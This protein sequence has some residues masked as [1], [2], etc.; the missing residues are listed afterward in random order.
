MLIGVKG[1][2]RCSA[3][4]LRPL[5]PIARQ[6]VKSFAVL[7]TRRTRIGILLC[8][9]RSG[10]SSFPVGPKP[11]EGFSISI[12][13]R[14]H[15]R[16]PADRRRT[17]AFLQRNAP[18]ANAGRIS[19]LCADRIRPEGR[20]AHAQAWFSL[21]FDGRADC[22]S[23]AVSRSHTERNPAVSLAKPLRPQHKPSVLDATALLCAVH[24]GRT[25]RDA[26]LKLRGSVNAVP[27]RRS[28]MFVNVGATR[29]GG[30]D[31]VGSVA[32]RA[33]PR[34]CHRTRESLGGAMRIA[35]PMATDPKRRKTATERSRIVL[36]MYLFERS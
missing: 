11:G 1:A 26:E 35:R 6:V 14:A 19:L 32:T 7:P 29:S 2:S 34:H 17:L 21:C 16:R 12:E 36:R 30:L 5:T 3:P 8:R 13:Q 22:Q 24:S 25:S 27:L 9:P 4:G 23:L 31:S 33:A 18:R 28:T 15:G 10:T 20:W